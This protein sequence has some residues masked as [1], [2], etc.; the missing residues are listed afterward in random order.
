MPIPSETSPLLPLPSAIALPLGVGVG[1]KPEHFLEIAAAPQPLAF[2]EVHAENYMGAGGL[3]HRQL[4]TL[5]ETYA[6]S[7]H[8]VGLS[9]GGLADLDV[10]HLQRVQEVCRRYQPESFSEHLAWATHDGLYLNDLLPLPYTRERLDVV[11]RHVDQVQSALKRRILIENPATYVV[12]EDSTLSET[13]FLAEIARRTGCGLLLDVN[14]VFVSAINHGRDAEAYLADFPMDAVG[15]LHLGG[16]DLAQDVGQ[17]GTE[18]QLLIDSHGA[19]VADPVWDLFSH[20]IARTGAL[21]T[22]VEWDND[23]PPWARLRAEAER[24]AHI[25]RGPARAAA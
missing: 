11:V 10:S 21:P 17:D 2:F 1:F 5:R 14:N 7:I 25:L 22:L 3:P 19:P 9:I 15:E 20:V 16:H 18:T 12:F 13:H 23:V 8:G 4:E 24:A 6:L